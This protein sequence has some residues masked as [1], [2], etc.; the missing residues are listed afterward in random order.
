MTRAME[1]LRKRAAK[2]QGFTLIEMAIVLIIIG[3]IIGAVLKGQ[4]LINNARGKKFASFVRQG[5]IAQWTYYDRNGYYAGDD[6]NQNG[7]LGETG[8]GDTAAPHDT[9]DTEIDSFDDTLSLGSSNFVIRYGNYDPGTG[10]EAPVAII[11]AKAEA[12]DPTAFTED[13]LNFAKSFDAG[14]DGAQDPDT[15]SVVALTSVTWDGTGEVFTYDYADENTD[16][17]T[18]TVALLYYFAGGNPD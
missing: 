6:G 14:V 4:D 9:L 18:S 5:E 11:I 15:G 1:T 12:T 2:E 17:D 3:L 16:W 8:S 10:A 13:E 7:I